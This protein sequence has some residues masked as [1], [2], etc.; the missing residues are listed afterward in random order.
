MEKYF[1][2]EVQKWQLIFFGCIIRMDE[3]RWPR[4]VQKWIPQEKHK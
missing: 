4:K 2:D 1:I 3:M